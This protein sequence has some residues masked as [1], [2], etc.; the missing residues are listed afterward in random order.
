MERL[1]L[2]KE[3]ACGLFWGNGIISAGCDSYVVTKVH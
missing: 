3:A 2:K 1:A